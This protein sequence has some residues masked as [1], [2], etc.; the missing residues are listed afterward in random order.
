MVHQYVKQSLCSV[1]RGQ[2]IP[3]TRNYKECLQGAISK[4]YVTQSMHCVK[5]EPLMCLHSF[6]FLN[7]P[8]LPL[9]HYLANSCRG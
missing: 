3:N 5:Y 2:Y 4:I 1:S 6:N 8:H 7:P 9:S